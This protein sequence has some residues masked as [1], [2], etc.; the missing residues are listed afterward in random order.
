[1]FVVAHYTETL[2]KTQIQHYPITE[3]NSCLRDIA[4]LYLKKGNLQIYERKKTTTMVV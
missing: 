1:M 3:H 2:D 4:V